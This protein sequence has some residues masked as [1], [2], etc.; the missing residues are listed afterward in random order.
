LSSPD[1]DSTSDAPSFVLGSFAST[2][3]SQAFCALVLLMAHS[4]HERAAGITSGRVALAADLVDLLTQLELDLASGISMDHQLPLHQS[5]IALLERL[6]EL[7]PYLPHTLF[8]QDQSREHSESG[9]ICKS[10]S[11]TSTATMKEPEG[12]NLPMSTTASAAEEATNPLNRISEELRP[13]LRRKTL[14]LAPGEP[15][16]MDVRSNGSQQSTPDIR[17]LCPPRPPPLPPPTPPPII[18]IQ[19]A[20][21]QSFHDA[22]VSPEMPPTRNPFVFDTDRAFVD[23][24]SGVPEAKPATGSTPKHEAALGVPNVSGRRISTRIAA[25]LPDQWTRARGMLDRRLTRAGGLDVHEP[26]SATSGSE[27]CPPPDRIPRTAGSGPRIGSGEIPP[28]RRRTES[29]SPSLNPG[30]Q[31][32]SVTLLYIN[33]CDINRIA[34]NHAL[35]IES[36]LDGA[37]TLVF[38]V[39]TRH[40]GTMVT[41]SGGRYLAGWNTVCR[42]SSHA[43][44]ACQCALQIHQELSKLTGWWVKAGVSLRARVS[45]TTCPATFG[46]IGRPFASYNLLGPGIG[47]LQA[48]DSLAK[49][50]RVRTV[51]TESSYELTKFAF[52]VRPVDRILLEPN[53]CE[54]IRTKVYELRASSTDSTAGDEWMYE[55]N[56]MHMLGD[57]DYEHAFNLFCQGDLLGAQLLLKM[58]LSAFPDDL[59]SKRLVS[60]CEFF[61]EDPEGCL[62]WDPPYYRRMVGPWQ[63]WAA[64]GLSPIDGSSADMKPSSVCE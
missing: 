5:L 15:C 52:A 1:S 59:N 25:L 53:G 42:V 50:L 11:L 30:L 17:V 2:L 56:G 23:L 60:L 20:S 36:L 3:V 9:R 41:F 7:K 22:H 18:S 24:V 44:K 6:I 43:Q 35:Q 49:V 61:L 37:T 14:R 12:G 8:V 34:R 63:R 58:Q 38:D 48:L 47:I 13:A 21:Q 40:R 4:H 45:I 54:P 39:V 28:G 33:L 62:A 27:E 55:L 10:Q 46:H 51:M 64:E 57:E 31:Q 19:S 16:V 29:L 32:R 26:T